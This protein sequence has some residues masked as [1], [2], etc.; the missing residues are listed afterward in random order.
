MQIPRK[1]DDNMYVTLVLHENDEKQ[2]FVLSCWYTG[3][4]ERIGVSKNVKF[5]IRKY[6]VWITK[7]W[8]LVS[9]LVQCWNVRKRNI[10]RY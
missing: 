7:K 10:E 4:S 3:Q 5:S 6:D 1:R 2:I 8:Q 9:I